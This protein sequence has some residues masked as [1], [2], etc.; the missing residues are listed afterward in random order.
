MKNVLR[1]SIENM[2]PDLIFCA[3]RIAL[4]SSKSKFDCWQP[5]NIKIKF[6]IFSSSGSK[7]EPPGGSVSMFHCSWSNAVWEFKDQM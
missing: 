7:R 3:I 5:T 2:Y 4:L 1:F 6:L